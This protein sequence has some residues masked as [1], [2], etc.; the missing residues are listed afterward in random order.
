MKESIREEE[1][2]FDLREISKSSL[3]NRQ[4]GSYLAENHL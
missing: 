1:Y 2:L 4:G 3:S